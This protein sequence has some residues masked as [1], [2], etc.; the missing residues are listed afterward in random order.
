[1]RSEGLV[2]PAKLFKTFSNLT[3]VMKKPGKKVK[4]SKAKSAK[5]LSKARNDKSLKF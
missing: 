2:A 5:K 3:L 1:M 4:S